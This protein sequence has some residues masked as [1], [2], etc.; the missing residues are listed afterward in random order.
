MYTAGIA[1]HSVGIRAAGHHDA[2]VCD[3][4]CHRYRGQ[5]LS[6]C[7]F[8]KFLSELVCKRAEAKQQG[9]RALAD[10]CGGRAVEFGRGV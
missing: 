6:K 7:Q 5:A 10:D 4:K 1:E 2:G 9:V 8:R 3:F